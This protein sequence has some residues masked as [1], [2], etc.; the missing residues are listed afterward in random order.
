MFPTPSNGCCCCSVAVMFDSFVTSWTV[1][2]QA[3]LSVEFPSKN[4]GEGIPSLPSP[5]D[6]FYLGDQA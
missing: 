6:L 1:A 3:P 4:I 5:G 2:R